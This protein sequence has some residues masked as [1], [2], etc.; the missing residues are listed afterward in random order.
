MRPAL[1]AILQ[2]AFHILKILDSGIGG[3]YLGRVELLAIPG[4]DIA[5]LAL[6]D[7]H[8][9]RHVNHILDRH[10][11][12]QTAA[13]DLRLVASLALQGDQAAFYRAFAAPAFFDHADAVVR[14]KANPGKH[15]EKQD[16]QNDDSYP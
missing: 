11:V 14:D 15:D 5:N 6:R 4:E 13:Q 10:Q 16:H 2:E 7:G 9:R 3:Q 12:M 1:P 8:Q